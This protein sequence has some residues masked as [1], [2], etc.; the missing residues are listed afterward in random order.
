MVILAQVIFSHAGDFA[1]L[2]THACAIACVF[3]HGLS[4]GPK[5]SFI[6]RQPIYRCIW[7]S[8]DVIPSH[9][10]IWYIK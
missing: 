10:H 7:L 6:L 4:L 1:Y 3:R 2:W 8:I 5:F 9:L